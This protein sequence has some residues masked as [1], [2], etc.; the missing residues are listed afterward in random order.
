MNL[1]EMLTGDG[2]KKQEYEDFASR[3]DR[4]HPSDGYTDEEVLDR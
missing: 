2:K 1:I 3:Y 4:G